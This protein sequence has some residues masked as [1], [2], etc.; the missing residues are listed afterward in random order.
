MSGCSIPHT[1][2]IHFV[3]GH[4]NVPIPVS[5]S[6]KQYH[7]GLVRVILSGSVTCDLSHVFSASDLMPF[8]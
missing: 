4:A 1:C 5:E 6:K 2:D 7:I 8:S 3:D